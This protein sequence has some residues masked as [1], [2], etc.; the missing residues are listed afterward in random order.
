M[1]RFLIKLFSW[2]YWPMWLVYLPVS[3]YYFYLAGRA[4]SF[5]FFSASNP[6]IETGGMFFES[7]WKIFQLIPLQYLPSTLL[8]CENDTVEK[9]ERNL[10]SAAMNFPLIAKPNRGERGWGV[11]KLNSKSELRAYRNQTQKEFIIQSYVDA[12]LEFSLFYYRNPS[13]SKGIISSL[14]LKKLLSVVGDGKASVREL[15]LKNDRAY[16]QY[17]RLQQNPEIDFNC[18]LESN[19][20]LV[21]VPYGNHVLGAMFVNYNHFIDATLTES[22]DKISKSINGFYFG[23]FDL[24]CPSFADL[25]NGTNIS[26]LELNGAGA[27]PAHIYDP[28]FSF[29]K[30]QKVIAQHYKM[31]FDA[32]RENRERGVEY[33]SFEGFKSTRM[34]E[35]N[36]KLNYFTT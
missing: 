23:R 2:E 28:S 11:R 22:F 26:I 21:L 5:F 4:K 15:I 36:Y 27:E 16:L 35:R 14:T 10:Q 32:A 1:R 13:S 31:M 3:F 8:V 30:A 34:E 29:F 17:K 9:I 6:S 12:P 20:E 19:E 33:M 24:R 18:I 7:K 25:R